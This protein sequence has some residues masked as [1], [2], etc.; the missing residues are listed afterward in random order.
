MTFDINVSNFFFDLSPKA[1]ATKAKI[2]KWNYNKLEI[3]CT[4]KKTINKPKGNLLNE[5][6]YLLM[7]YLIRG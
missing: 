2:N 7:I 1:R 3:F 4:V 6:K 5:R